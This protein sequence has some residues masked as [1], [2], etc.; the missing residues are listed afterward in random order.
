M[1]TPVKKQWAAAKFNGDFYCVTTYSGYR[2]IGA[3]PMGKEHLLSPD[4]SDHELGAAVLDAL[5]ASRFLSLAEAYELFDIG[6]VEQRY[7]DWVT[8]LMRRFGYQTRGA[9]FK[10]M[11]RCGVESYEGKIKI[12]PSHHEKLESWTG[13]GIQASDQVVLPEKSSPE[14]VGSALRLAFSRCT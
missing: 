10:N 8:A 12:R 2:S 14:E 5:S 13:D 3:D 9:L 11:S 4:V 6:A 1:D 7:S